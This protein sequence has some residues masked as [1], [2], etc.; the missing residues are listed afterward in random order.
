[1]KKTLLA[2]TII[3]SY[4]V[5]LFA[6]DTT[7]IKNNTDSTRAVSHKHKLFIAKDYLLYNYTA[8]GNNNVFNQQF[9]GDADNRIIVD[10]NYYSNS[11]G[12]PASLG[13]NLLFNLPI[14]TALLDRA[15]KH[16]GKELKFEENLST[17]LTYEHYF[18]KADLTLVVGY[19]Y[20]QMLNLN[21]P[22]QAFET[23]FYGNSRFE[24]DTAKTFEVVIQLGSILAVVVMFW[25]SLPV[26]NAPPR[27]LLSP[28]PI[29][30]ME[31]AVTS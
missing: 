28:P 29:K 11:V 27:V 10:G 7:A 2:F 17:G 14:T 16:L 13:Y 23:I 18:K 24:G 8:Q 31:E 22:K 1:M 25:P 30:V 19:N 12:V 21:G 20:R 26:R 5:P 3:F 6:Q 15:D 4:I 9:R